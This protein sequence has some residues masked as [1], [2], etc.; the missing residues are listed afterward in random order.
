M[1]ISA[2]FD[3]RFFAFGSD[4]AT[5]YVSQVDP[6]SQMWWYAERSDDSRATSRTSW[7]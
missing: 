7:R 2:F 3:Q 4:E 5:Y 6:T 1:P